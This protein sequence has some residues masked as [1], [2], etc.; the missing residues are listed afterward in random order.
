M[1]HALTKAISYN[2]VN[3]GPGS[4]PGKFWISARFGMDAT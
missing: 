2:R 1:K 4:K 3:A